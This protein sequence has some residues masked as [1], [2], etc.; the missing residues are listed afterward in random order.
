M[1]RYRIVIL[2]RSLIFFFR[3]FFYALYYTA[4]LKTSIRNNKYIFTSLQNLNI[5]DL[6]IENDNKQNKTTMIVKRI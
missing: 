1:N 6:E 4:F 5:V 3:W 2:Y